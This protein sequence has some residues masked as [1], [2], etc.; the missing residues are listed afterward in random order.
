M[1][2]AIKNIRI[3]MVDNNDSRHGKG[4]AKIVTGIDTT[5]TNGYAIEGDFL[6]YGQQYDLPV[7]TIILDVYYFGS[8]KHM[9]KY[10]KIYTVQ[11]SGLVSV[12][13]NDKVYDYIGSFLSMRD[14]LAGLLNAQKATEPTEPVQENPLAQFSDEQILAEAKISV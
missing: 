6:R 10:A 12:L 9:H 4:W 1:E 5:K 13:E 7:G 8:M 3:K 2:N 11:E 14:K